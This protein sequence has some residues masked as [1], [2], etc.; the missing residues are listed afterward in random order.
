[1]TDIIHAFVAYAK[2][3]GS[4]HADRYYLAISHMVN[5]VILGGQ[6][7]RDNL[8]AGQ[9]VSLTMAERICGQSLQEAMQAGLP[10]KEC[11]RIAKERVASLAALMS[12]AV[13]FPSL[14]APANTSHAVRMAG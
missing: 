12:G 6:V 13:P 2:G 10:Y 8:E 9:L 1:M 11:F 14:P 7:S 4:Q 3:Q 5:A